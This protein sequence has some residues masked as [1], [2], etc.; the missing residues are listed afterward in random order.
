MSERVV[1]VNEG[2]VGRNIVGEVG[3]CIQVLD[4]KINM[5]RYMSITNEDRSAHPHH[6]E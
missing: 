2:S 5:C 1:D 3:M 6:L 4:K